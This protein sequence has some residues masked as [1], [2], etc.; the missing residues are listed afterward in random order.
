MDALAEPMPGPAA[1]SMDTEW[2][3]IDDLGHVARFLTDS[4]GAV[5]V[6]H[7]FG[8]GFETLALALIHRSPALRER[9]VA[10]REIGDEYALWSELD[11]AALGLFDF[12]YDTDWGA[13]IEYSDLYAREGQPTRALKIFELPVH[14][15]AIIEPLHLV[16]VD[17]RAVERLQP[18]EHLPCQ[19]WEG[20][21][22]SDGLVHPREAA[23]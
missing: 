10:L 3:G 17:F 19:V 2:F 22:G 12:I 11:P 14:L 16:G 9:F 4:R 18:A 6:G 1:H 5:A 8:F 7:P 23:R 15:R 13:E 20:F 21:M